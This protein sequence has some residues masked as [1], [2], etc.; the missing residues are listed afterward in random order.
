LLDSFKTCMDGNTAACTD[1]SKIQRFVDTEFATTV[2]VTSSQN[3]MAAAD[4]CFSS[5]NFV[6]MVGADVCGAHS[7]YQDCMLRALQPTDDGCD[8][9]LIMAYRQ[10]ASDVIDQVYAQYS[11]FFA[12][13]DEFQLDPCSEQIAACSTSAKQALTA[14]AASSYETS[15]RELDSF[16]NCMNTD[17]PACADRDRINSFNDN[18]NANRQTNYNAIR[19]TNYNAIRQAN[20]NAIR[21]A[22]YNAIRQANYNAIRQANYNAIRQANYNAIRQANYNAIR[23]ANYNAI[24]QANYN[25]IRQANY[26][27]ASKR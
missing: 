4:E 19:Q 14:F 12:V 23:Q 2:P 15:C 10:F 24:R 27:N 18:N 17:T 9:L 11:C 8:E 22:N 7:F 16:K 20:Y 3:C 1:R 21:Q 6:L 5:L 25:A 13:A 26:N